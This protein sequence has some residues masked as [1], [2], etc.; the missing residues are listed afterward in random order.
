MNN[1]PRSNGLDSLRSAAILLVFMYHYAVFFSHAP[2]FGFW[3]EIGW[4]GVDLFF[5]LSGYLI[6]N[7]ILSA[8]AHQRAFSLKNF[9]ARRLLRTLPNYWFVLALYF[10]FPVAMGG[11]TP[12]SLW[13][14]LSFTQNIGL[15]AGTAFS[16]A[17]SLCI[18]E[19]FYL[20]LPAVAL[21]LAAY[22]KSVRAGWILL[23]L[24]VVVA[25][26]AR[27]LLW[28]QYHDDPDGWYTWVYYSSLCR[29]DELLAGVAVAMLKNF[30]R[31]AW[32]RIMAKGNLMLVLGLAATALM[33]Y[34]FLN[35]Q[36]VDG[37]GYGFFLTAVGYPLLAMSFA[38][39]VLA[40]LGP[41]S[42]LQR[43]RVPGAG[44]LA[45][46][47]YA[48]YLTHKPLMHVLGKP[49]ADVGVVPDSAVAALLVACASIAAGCLLYLA[50]ETPFMRLRERI[51]PQRKTHPHPKL[52]PAP[53]ARR[54]GEGA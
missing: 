53:G 40:A 15:H 38:L 29:F 45:R 1:A 35:Y 3:S 10:L 20:V 4:T 33:F 24:A 49:L 8:L 14:F 51:S 26:T 47:S 27:I 16:H 9:Y 6:G 19:Q 7:Q 34:L 11:K 23:A 48:I 42:L 36:Y 17:W 54:R 5:V 21:L 18:E 2:T 30:H 13:R 46:W 28:Q 31:G 25:T 44:R 43:M 12:P 32:E 52:P 22:G 41:G 37:A 39:L 50:V